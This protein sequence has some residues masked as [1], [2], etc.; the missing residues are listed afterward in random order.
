VLNWTTPLKQMLPDLAAKMRA[1]YRSV[2]LVQLLSHQ[3]GLPH[4]RRYRTDLQH[5]HVHRDDLP[6]ALLRA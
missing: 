1:E 5:K 4:L 2:T 3:S 6:T